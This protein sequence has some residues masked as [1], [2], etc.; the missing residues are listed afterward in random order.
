MAAASRPG[1]TLTVINSTFSGNSADYGA[2]LYMQSGAT[3]TVT[4]ST[5]SGNTAINN[6]GAI[7]SQDSTT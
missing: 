1:G 5:L 6:G 3:A 2:G 7:Y 4:S